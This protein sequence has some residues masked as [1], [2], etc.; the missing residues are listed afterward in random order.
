MRLVP[1]RQ[2]KLRCRCPLV[3]ALG[4]ILALA[5]IAR[6]EE[7]IAACRVAGVMV[8]VVPQLIPPPQGEDGGRSEPGGGMS[9]RSRIEISN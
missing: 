3:G 4:A 2:R 1:D 8:E 7:E 5:S 6:A 9:G